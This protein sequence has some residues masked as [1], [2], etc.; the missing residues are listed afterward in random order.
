MELATL[1]EA[2]RQVDHL[3]VQ[4]KE[5]DEICKVKRSIDFS[6]DEYLILWG[7]KVLG[8]HQNV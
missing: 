7:C 5:M 1:H 6:W 2:V 8:K 4:A 3:D